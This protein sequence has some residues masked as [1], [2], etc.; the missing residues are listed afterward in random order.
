MSEEAHLGA[1]ISRAGRTSTSPSTLHLAGAVQHVVLDAASAAAR[2]TA[3]LPLPTT[4]QRR[5]T[6]HALSVRPSH[7][8]SA[9]ECHL[10]RDLHQM[11]CRR[12]GRRCTNRRMRWDTATPMLRL[13]SLRTHTPL[14]T[15]AVRLPRHSIPLNPTSGSIKALHHGTPNHRL[16]CHTNRNMAWLPCARR[17]LHHSYHVR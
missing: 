14:R 8:Q 12:M 4:S 1:L 2:P 5:F 17:A 7:L 10:T 3:L 6:C 16:P 13:C 11:E 9:S 15:P